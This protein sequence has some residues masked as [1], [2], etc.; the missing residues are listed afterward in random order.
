ML[1]DYYTKPLQGSLFR[2]FRN[3]IM[4]YTSISDIID[5]VPEIK[6][7]VRNLAQYKSE[8]LSKVEE[9]FTK[10]SKDSEE[11]LSET[12]GLKTVSFDLKNNTIHT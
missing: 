9:H 10:K 7:R 5:E 11:H 3:I 1:A 4:G 12:R 2:F 8:M 6:E